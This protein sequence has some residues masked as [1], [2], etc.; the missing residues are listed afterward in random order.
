MS[1][2]GLNVV[3]YIPYD[4]SVVEADMK[5]VSLLDYDENSLAIKETINLKKYLIEMNKT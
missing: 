3:A 2:L 5:G 1:E 4:L